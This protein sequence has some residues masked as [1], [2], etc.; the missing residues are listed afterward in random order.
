MKLIPVL[1]LFL[2]FTAADAGIFA[3]PCHTNTFPLKSSAIV[4][5]ENIPPVSYKQAYVCSLHHM[6]SSAFFYTSRYI[7]LLKLSS[8]SG[9]G[10]AIVNSLFQGG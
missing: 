5:C 3:R 10:T 6:N 4:R 2:M 1:F 9:E 7:Y 8:L